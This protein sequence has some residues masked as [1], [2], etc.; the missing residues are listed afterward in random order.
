MTVTCPVP[1]SA[2]APQ[3]PSHRTPAPAAPQRRARPAAAEARAGG[4][5]VLLPRARRPGGVR[6]AMNAET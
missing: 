4:G 6:A 1:A 3:R 2:L 5:D